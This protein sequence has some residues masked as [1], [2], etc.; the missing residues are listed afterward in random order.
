MPRLNSPKVLE[1]NEIKISWGKDGQIINFE[2]LMLNCK[3]GD[4]WLDDCLAAR[5]IPSEL[6]RLP[7]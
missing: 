1:F 2:C 3:E 7:R 6:G 5:M 4:E